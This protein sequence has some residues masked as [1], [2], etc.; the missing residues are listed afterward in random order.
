MSK[1][2]ASTVQRIAA[3]SNEYLE[4]GDIS[5]RKEWTFA[6]DVAEAIL[7]L[8]E[9]DKVFEAVIGSGKA[10]SIEQW[11]ECCFCLIGKNW[12]DYVK[13]NRSFNPEYRL[14]V[15]NPATMKNLGW[16]PKKDIQELA[17]MMMKPS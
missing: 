16:Q 14:L 3:G 17:A 15:S 1:I 12:R 7:L 8:L 5:V 11:L 2:I 4:L 10:Y 9:Q 13:L 6:G